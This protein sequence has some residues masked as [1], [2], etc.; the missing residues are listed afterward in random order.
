MADRYKCFAELT[1]N[2]R[3]GIDYRICVEDRGAQLVVF[4]PHGGWIEPN[5]S[6]IAEAVAGLDFSFY[7]FEGLE[8]RP[9]TDLHITSHRYRATMQMEGSATSNLTGGADRRAG[10]ARP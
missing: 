10:E 9:H 8:N 7:A 6:E 3:L 1:A 4:A 2:E 5:T